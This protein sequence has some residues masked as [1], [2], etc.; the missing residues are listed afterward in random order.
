MTKKIAISV[1]DDVAE[2]LASEPNVSA[3]V[4]VAVRQ[5]MV[6]EQVRAMQVAAG[7]ELTEEDQRKAREVWAVTEAA[8]TPELVAEA[9]DKFGPLIHARAGGSTRG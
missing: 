2:R 6:S 7:L 8:I 4:T 3:Y 9:W 5:R 1:P